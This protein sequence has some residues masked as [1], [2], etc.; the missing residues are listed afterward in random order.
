VKQGHLHAALAL[1]SLATLVYELA[2]MRL[3]S[4]TL[5]YYFAFFAISLALLGG[6]AAAALIFVRRAWIAPR[7]ERLLPLAALLHGLA[8]ALAPA[9]YLK[10]HLVIFSGP[11]AI[12]N[13]ALILLLFFIPFLLG[14][15]VAA[16]ILSFFPARVASLYWADLGGASAGCL[17]IVP[18]LW[19]VPAPSLMAWTGLL[20]VA[21][22]LLLGLGSGGGRLSRAQIAGGSIVLL[23]AVSSLTSW[24]PYRVTFSKIRDLDEGLIYTRWTPLARLSVYRSVFFVDRQRTPFGWGMSPRFKGGDLDQ[25]WIEQDEC[26]GTPITRFDG[27]AASLSF[28]EYDVTNFAYRYRKFPRVL[29]VGAGGGRDIL[30]ARHFGAERVTAVEINPAMVDIVDSVF[31]DFSG[32]PYAL[33]GVQAVVD[34]ARNYLARSRETWD[35]IQI[36]LIDSW[37][38]SMAGAFALAENNLYTVEAFGIDLDRLAPD[39]VLAVSRWYN[40]DSASE[41]VRLVNLAA[42]ALARREIRDPGR[43]IAVVNGHLVGTTLV[44]KRPFTEDELERIERAADDLEFRKLWIPG[45]A[46]E[47]TFIARLLAGGDRAAY[48]AGLPLDVSPSTDDRPFF[49]LHAKS[50]LNP[51]PPATRAGL[52][53]AYSPVRALRA[54]FWLLVGAAFAWTILPLALARQSA[55][56]LGRVLVRHPQ[57]WLYFAGIGAGFMLVEVCLIQRYVLFLGHPTYASSVVIFSLLV[58]ASLGSASTAPLGRRFPSPRLG[59]IALSLIVSLVAVQA[60]LVPPLLSAAMAWRIGPRIAFAALLLAPLGYAMG[61]AFPLGIR[62]LSTT[63]TEAMIPYLWGINGVFSVF[64]SVL[65]TIVAVGHGYGTGLTAGLGAYVLALVMTL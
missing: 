50:I 16:A 55:F 19:I 30:A 14:G 13:L 27:D 51:P 42:E 35:L 40:P 20:A 7:V 60:W 25:R 33:P 5:W 46:A 44:S 48:V 8:C 9:I 63:D 59:T 39:G 36:S 37:A 21:A 64:G 2:L 3:F 10:S 26:A 49:F 54:L 57:A 23:L 15:G 61:M 62:R 29:I 11:W 24:N 17:L 43:H 58:S 32:R 47:D 28:L 53:Y 1:T 38:A 56:S 65:A 18:L 4:V 22:S 45:K 6:G 12:V 31:G 52:G 41:T 34:E